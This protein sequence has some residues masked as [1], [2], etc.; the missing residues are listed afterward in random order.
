MIAL[1]TA[2]KAVPPLL[3]LNFALDPTWKNAQSPATRWCV[4]PVASSKTSICPDRT[5]LVSS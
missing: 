5:Y 2:K 1:V 3:L 4:T